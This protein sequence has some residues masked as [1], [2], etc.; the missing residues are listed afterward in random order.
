M[1]DLSYQAVVDESCILDYSSH[2]SD[3]WYVAFVRTGHEREAF[4]D[5]NIAYGGEDISAFL[6][7]IEMPFKK[8]GAVHKENHLMFPGYVF[9]SSSMAEDEF[10]QEINGFIRKSKHALR[11]LQYGASGQAAL[12]DYERKVLE[13]LW[14]ESTQ[15]IEMS[16]GILKGN[17]LVITQGPLTGRENKVVKIDRHSMK[18]TTEIVLFGET[19]TVTVG[20]EIAEK[21]QVDYQ[22]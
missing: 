2:Y 1:K 21:F 11:L 14:D 5:V 4:R 15:R 19:R 9:F 20:V 8:A 6:P 18:A 12:Y 10:I 17:Q 16:R 3:R 13:D 22:I 7:S